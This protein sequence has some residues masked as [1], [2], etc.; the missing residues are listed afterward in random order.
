M[1]NDILIL[2]SG[3]FAKEVAFLIEE[4]NKKINKW[5]II[6]YVDKIEFIGR[7]NGKYKVT[8]T[9]DE[10]I[11]KND[12][13]NI[14]IG[15]GNPIILNAIIE[16]LKNNSSIKYPNLIHPNVI[17]DW[18]NIKIGIGNII[19]ANNVFTTDIKIGSFNIFNLACT[20][21]HDTQIG[22]FSVFNPNVNISGGGG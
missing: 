18:Q 19:T 16:K 20:V 9:E 1:K 12:E 8:T 6:G 14:A 13:I 3:G 22:D 15:I 11:N 17:A 7:K 4:I 2:G 10:L 21:G 5:N